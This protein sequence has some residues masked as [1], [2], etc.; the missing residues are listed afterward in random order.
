MIVPS[1]HKTAVGLN[2]PLFKH[3]TVESPFLYLPSVTLPRYQHTKQAIALTPE[4][5]FHGPLS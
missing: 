2:T 1:L 3:I 4:V 5:K